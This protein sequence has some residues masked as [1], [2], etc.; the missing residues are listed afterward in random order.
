MPTPAAR[1]L[2][3][4]E[5]LQSRPSVTGP[6]LAERLGVDRRTV[7]RYVSALQELGIPV[8]GERGVGGGYRLGAGYRLPPLMF[9]DDEATALVL[10][11]HA[12]RA[13]PAAARALVKVQ[14]VLPD[15]LRGPAEA[16]TRVATST[17]APTPAT[18]PGA[19]LELGD[20]IAR[21]RRV[22]ARS[23]RH[24][25]EERRRE[26][27][28]YGLVAHGDRWYLV[29][30]DHARDAVRTFR[31]SRLHDVR[32]GGPATPPPAGFDPAAHVRRSLAEVPWAW[33]VVVTLDLPAEEALARVPPTLGVLDG[34]TLTLRAERLDW[35]ARFLASLDCAFD[36]HE[37]EELRD[38]LRTLADRLAQASMSPR[39]IA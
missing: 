10:G 1:L 36:V 14:R 20:A 33:T 19:L 17:G 2:D 9:D 7:R 38:A 5:V 22:L 8:A 39:R 21:G 25:G 37:P 18:A 29:A 26:L 16:L 13:Q 4:L 32:L 27:S 28:P 3:V 35:A 15:R 34:A 24:D 11:L 6:E 12:V 31:T 23:T 30:H